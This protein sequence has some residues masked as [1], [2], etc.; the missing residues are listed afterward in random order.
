MTKD[1]T[2]G[3]PM[4]LILG[5]AVPLMFG[6]LLQQMYSMADTMIVGKMLGASS[7]AAVG[8]S[9]A[10]NFLVIGFC[11]GIC[12]GFAIPIAQRFG[13][14]D[15]KGLRRFLANSIWLAAAAAIILTIATVAMCE[16]I[17]HLIKTPDDIFNEACGYIRVIFIG[18]PATILYNMLSAIIRSLGDSRTP[19]VFLALAA[20]LNVILDI[21]FV[22]VLKTD[23]SGT[24]VAT[25]I[26]Q[27]ISGIACLIYMFK[28]FP[29]LHIG[30][31]ELKFNS[32]CARVLCG[33]GIPMGLQYSITAIGSVI[34]QSSV[35]S[36]GTTYVASMSGASKMSFFCMCPFDTLGT[37]MATYGGQNVGAGRLDRLNGGLRSAITIAFIYSA[38][39]FV[40][41]LLFARPLCSLF[42]DGGETE[43]IGYMRQFLLTNSAF[44]I[45]LS[46]VNIVR[47]MIQGMGFGSFSLFSGLSEMVARALFGLLLVPVFGFTAACFASPAAWLFADLFL[48]PGYLH[49]LKKLKCTQTV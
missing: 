24:A 5:F 4:R 7:L 48:I 34:L 43:I 15:M 29:M 21:L 17:M 31:D 12:S 22:G 26:S 11:T 30:K 46:L 33:I 36:L 42:V 25:V 13:A 28:K 16:P 32:H 10:V 18:I 27:G 49:C 41:L 47:F 3:S 8:S 2:S 38:A 44:Y 19:V 23:A 20:V 39:A 35:N 6:L 45:L 9:G 14:G 37:T 1:L 40:L